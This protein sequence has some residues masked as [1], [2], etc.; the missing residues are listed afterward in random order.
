MEQNSGKTFIL[1]KDDDNLQ[2][3]A[4]VDLISVNETFVKFKTKHNT[5][6]LAS[7]RVLKIKEKGEDAVGNR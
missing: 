6:T 7:N 2:V 4:W 3:T 1:Y 5:I